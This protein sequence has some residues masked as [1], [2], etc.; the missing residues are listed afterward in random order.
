MWFHLSRITFEI[1]DKNFYECIE[2]SKQIF[3]MYD[4]IISNW[5][6]LYDIDY[7]QVNYEKYIMCELVEKR[8]KT[9]NFERIVELINHGCF[10]ALSCYISDLMDEDLRDNKVIDLIDSLLQNERIN[11]MEFEK[12]LLIAMK[13]ALKQELTYRIGDNVYWTDLPDG[14]VFYDKLKVV[15]ENYVINYYQAM[16]E[17]ARIHFDKS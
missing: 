12:G 14:K 11:D 17:T 16:L 5:G 8:L 2:M 6:I 10:T 4:D 9:P 13:N 7:E 1:T 15:N 3:W